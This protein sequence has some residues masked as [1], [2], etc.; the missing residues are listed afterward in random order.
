MAGRRLLI[1]IDNCE[2]VLSAAVA[3]IEQ[4]IARSDTPRITATSRERLLVAGEAVVS[5]A[6][7]ALDGGV[8]SDAVTLFV[9][10]AGTVRPGFGIFDEQTAAAVVEICETLDGL[11]LGIELARRGWPR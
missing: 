6:P 7:L 9:E 4:V 3:A 8:T 5:V 1:V 11:P 10:R 2:H